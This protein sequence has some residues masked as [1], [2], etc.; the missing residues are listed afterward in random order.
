MLAR[1]VEHDDL[2]AAELVQDLSAGTAREAGGGVGAYDGDESYL[3]VVR[4]RGDHPGG[5]VAL[6]ADREPVGGVLDVATG[7]DGTAP[8][9][10]RSADPEVAVWG[11]GFERGRA[12]GLDNV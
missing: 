11:V 1:G 7:V 3:A 12:R 4:V 6:G 9:Q 5:G 8:G 10:D 2:F